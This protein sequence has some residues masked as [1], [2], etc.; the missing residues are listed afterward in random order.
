M[1]HINAGK[2]SLAAPQLSPNFF[3]RCL[4]GDRGGG[5]RRVAGFEKVN[6]LA[7]A[8]ILV[9]GVLE[10]TTLA[11]KRSVGNAMKFTVE[12][13]ALERMVEQLKFDR[14]T[15]GPHQ[16]MMRLS[17]CA[18]RVFVEANGVAAGIEALV[19]EDGGCNVP[20]MKLL[21]VLRTFHPKQ[22]IT[23]AA[24]A[25]GLRVAGF[26]M[27]ATH[28]S[29]VATA[30]GEFQ[31]FPVTDG[32]LAAQGTPRPPAANVPSAAPDETATP[33]QPE[34]SRWLNSRWWE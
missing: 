28:F 14:C 16:R 11:V 3:A 34:K 20:R 33:P 2:R 8:E 10:L 5:C 25:S 24:D 17:A 32:W 26:V 7:H 21:K 19:L 29:S 27:K 22:N 4:T 31:E 18:P 9:K 23:L 13:V 12:R 30:P 15:T 6:G 1:T